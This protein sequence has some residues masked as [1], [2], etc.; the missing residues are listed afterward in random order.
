MLHKALSCALCGTLCSGEWPQTPARQRSGCG[1]RPAIG[2]QRSLTAHPRDLS[3]PAGCIRA[4]LQ[5]LARL[6]A[7]PPS[8]HRPR[9]VVSLAAAGTRPLQQAH[10]GNSGL[11]PASLLPEGRGGTGVL[12]AS[13][14]GWTGSEC[15]P[16]A[17]ACAG[18]SAWAR[19]CSP[20]NCWLESPSPL[21]LASAPKLSFTNQQ[22]PRLARS[23][24]FLR[25]SSPLRSPL[26]GLLVTSLFS[27]FLPVRPPA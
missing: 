2:W 5:W 8:A 14:A 10:Q 22:E 27:L 3:V 11:V 23:L 7:G 16:G 12:G 25:P 15:G 26:S 9:P 13:R 1:L 24:L 21:G 18:S 20:L 4:R 6:D 19:R 17:W